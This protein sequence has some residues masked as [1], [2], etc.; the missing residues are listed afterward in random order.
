[1]FIIATIS[2]FASLGQKMKYGIVKHSDGCCSDNRINLK[3]E[4]PGIQKSMH[5]NQYDHLGKLSET[6]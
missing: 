3:H 1:M 4:M 2:N 5:V 6:I